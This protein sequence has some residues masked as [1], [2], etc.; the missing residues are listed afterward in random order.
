MSH[1]TEL[2]KTLLDGLEESLPWR[3][4][5]I[6]LPGD[7]QEIATIRNNTGYPVIAP[8]PE[9]A[10]MMVAQREVFAFIEQGPEIIRQLIAEIEAETP[11]KPAN[12]RNQPESGENQG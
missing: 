5:E 2:A 4:N 12:K 1:A 8:H 7:E 6:S 9:S 3:V 10:S 11:D